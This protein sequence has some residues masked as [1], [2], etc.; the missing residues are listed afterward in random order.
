MINKSEA[1][2]F[3]KKFGKDA[4]KS[5]RSISKDLS[6]RFSKIQDKLPV[7]RG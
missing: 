5:Y 7:N 3:L 4:E 2:R 6:K 1:R